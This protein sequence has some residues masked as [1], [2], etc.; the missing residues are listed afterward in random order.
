MLVFMLL[1]VWMKKKKRFIEGMD[2]KGFTHAH[3]WPTDK[4]WE[5]LTWADSM[6]AYVTFISVEINSVF[7]LCVYAAETHAKYT[8]HHPSKQHQDGYSPLFLIFAMFCDSVIVQW[9]GRGMS[10]PAAVCGG[11]GKL[12]HC[13]SYFPTEGS[14]D[15]TSG[16]FLVCWIGAALDQC[17]CGNTTHSSGTRPNHLYVIWKR[18]ESTVKCITLWSALDW[19]K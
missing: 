2:R 10:E 1:R 15:I 19:N 4:H 18:A 17:L 13:P 11:W 7:L 6:L 5:G 16:L 9:R 8:K 12:C 3:R 14:Y